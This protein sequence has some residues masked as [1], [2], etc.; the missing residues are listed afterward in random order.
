MP[1][2]IGGRKIEIGSAVSR[3]QRAAEL[4]RHLPAPRAIAAMVSPTAY[5][6]AIASIS[7]R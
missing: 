2:V 3:T 6:M 7:I 1:V 5:R 4:I